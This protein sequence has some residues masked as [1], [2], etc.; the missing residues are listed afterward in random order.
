LLATAGAI[1]FFSAEAMVPVPNVELRRAP[2]C[3]FPVEWVGRGVACLAR[4]PGTGLR[5]G[6]RLDAEGRAI[7]RMGPEA[8]AAFE[9]AVDPNRAD[10]DEL[11]SLP[12]VGAR[13]AERIVAE[14][15][16]GGPYGSVEALGRVS[17]IGDRTIERL[18]PRIEIESP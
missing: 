3:P 17:G 16:R 4:S 2:R 11:A 18:R 8:L 14:R 9:V 13:L 10:V 6:D 1:A 12:G 5:P 15:A 7:G